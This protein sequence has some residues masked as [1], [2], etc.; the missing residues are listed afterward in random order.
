[1]KNGSH[2]AT[3]LA[4]RTALPFVIATG[5]Q[6]SGGAYSR[7]SSSHTLSKAPEVL[8]RRKGGETGVK[9]VQ[10]LEVDDVWAAGN[11]GRWSRDLLSSALSRSDTPMGLTVLDGR[12]QDLVAFCVL[13]QLVKD[14][15]AY[16]LEYADGTCATLLLLNGAIMDNSSCR[17]LPT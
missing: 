6:R 14:P 11:A 7:P 1:M 8:E 13:P 3:T 9:A 16:C 2:S 15:A 17:R 10:L 4:G 5:A 12:T